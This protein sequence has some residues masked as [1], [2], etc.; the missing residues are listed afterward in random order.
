MEAAWWVAYAWGLEPLRG[1][2]TALESEW[3]LVL[4]GATFGLYIVLC[5]QLA[6]GD[7]TVLEVTKV[8]LH[9]E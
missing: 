2:R 3:H 9:P 4:V 8:L 5:F 6:R 7:L 1:L